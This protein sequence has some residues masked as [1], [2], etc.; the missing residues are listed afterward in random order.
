VVEENLS[1]FFTGILVVIIHQKADSN[2][3]T[4]NEQGLVDPLSGDIKHLP[5]ECEEISEDAYKQNFVYQSCTNIS[6]KPEKAAAG[7]NRSRA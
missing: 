3:Q 2:T 1:R 4:D 7:R 6:P 5:D